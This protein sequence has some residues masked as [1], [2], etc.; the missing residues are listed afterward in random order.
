M[1]KYKELGYRTM[2]MVGDTDGQCTLHG[3]REWIKSMGWQVS[4]EWESYQN[5]AN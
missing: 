5:K 1:A 3:I 2:H 4:K